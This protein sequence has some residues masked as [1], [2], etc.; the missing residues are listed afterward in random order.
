VGSSDH[1]RDKRGGT[2]AEDVEQQDDDS[3]RNGE[4]LTRGSDPARNIRSLLTDLSAAIVT[5]AVGV[6]GT[7][8]GV[9]SSYLLSIR[10]S[11]SQF[12]VE[13]AL[14]IAASEKHVWSVD[15]SAFSE[16]NA[17]VQRIEARLVVARIDHELRSAFATVTLECWYSVRESVEIDPH[18]YA[19]SSKVLEARQ[20]VTTAVIAACC[21]LT[22]G[23]L[24]TSC[25]RPLSP[26]SASLCP[27]G[28][29][30]CHRGTFGDTDSLGSPHHRGAGT[31]Q[32]SYALDEMSTDGSSPRTTAYLQQGADRYR[33][34]PGSCAHATLVPKGRAAQRPHEPRW[35]DRAAP[36]NLTGWT[37]F[38]EDLDRVLKAHCERVAYVARV[39]TDYEHKFRGTVGETVRPTCGDYGRQGDFHF[40]WPDEEPRGA[41]DCVIAS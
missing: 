14:E 16:L 31:E 12:R 5:G 1:L 23:P 15:E 25:R 9:S 6:A 36:T 33:S 17:V 38:E 7:V 39:T 32:A 30:P 28:P 20:S 4:R 21:I 3:E 29:A 24:A 27:R 26:W 40:T 18:N 11:R 13:T 10:Q 22:V 34:E 2:D 37:V 8:L 19:I 41:T 35:R